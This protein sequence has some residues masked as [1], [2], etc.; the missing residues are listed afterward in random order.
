MHQKR[1]HT[2]PFGP[3]YLDHS[4]PA[5]L[6]TESRATGIEDDD[7]DG[8]SG[9]SKGKN[10]WLNYDHRMCIGKRQQQRQRQPNPSLIMHVKLCVIYLNMFNFDSNSYSYGIAVWHRARRR[11][12][13]GSDRQ[14]AGRAD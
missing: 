6:S 2:A 4:A 8:L 10:Q 14:A 11:S 5:Y 7:D 1:A 3:F 9:E 13:G 12:N